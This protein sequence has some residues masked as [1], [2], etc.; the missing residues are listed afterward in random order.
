MN[1]NLSYLFNLFSNHA[2][3]ENFNNFFKVSICEIFNKFLTNF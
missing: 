3:W 1:K 2:Q